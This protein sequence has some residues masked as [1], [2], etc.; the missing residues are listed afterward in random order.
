[1]SLG[2]QRLRY[3]YLATCEGCM[4]F[5]PNSP[6]RTWYPCSKGLRMLFG[7]TAN[8]YDNADYGKNYWNHWNSGDT[9]SQAWQDSLLDA[10]S[11]QQPS[12]MAAGASGQE[13]S[14]RLFNE[15]LFYGGS[16]SQAW[17]WWR[18]VGNAPGAQ[19]E[20]KSKPA[21]F[22]LPR[23]LRFPSVGPRVADR[24]TVLAAM[25]R[26]GF[27]A[28]AS[29]PDGPLEGLRVSDGQQ[30]FAAL[31]DGFLVEFQPAT[32]TRSRLSFEQAAKAADAFAVDGSELQR[33]AVL[34]AYHTGGPANSAAVSEAE[35]YEHIVI[36]RQQVHGLPV[37]TPG[38]GELR[39]HVNGSGDIRRV[40][41]TRLDI[42]TVRESGSTPS[43]LPKP[44]GGETKVNRL[45]TEAEITAALRKAARNLSNGGGQIERNLIPGHIEIGFALR[46]TDLVPV[47]R[48]TVRIGSGQYH[49]LEAIE[50]DLIG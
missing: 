17:F 10:D 5:P 18:W 41:D 47:A 20:E 26:L 24:R 38:A 45:E 42:V 9:F 37:L 12:S 4:V 44:D 21:A 35:L 27:T 3:L 6:N 40:L 32:P 22:R 23:K 31:P 16:V 15:R 2:D 28:P 14:D 39:V 13:A 33:V 49:M 11:G 19:A 29:L 34:P 36:Y 46:G 7:A 48:A 43:T 25:K 8:I 30:R 1:M 50:V